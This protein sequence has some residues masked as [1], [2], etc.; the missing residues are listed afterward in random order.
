MIPLIVANHFPMRYSGG[1]SHEYAGYIS[2][3]NYT[4]LALERDSLEPHERVNMLHEVMVALIRQKSLQAID[5]AAYVGSAESYHAVLEAVRPY[6]SERYSE[7]DLAEVVLAQ[8]AETKLYLADLGERDVDEDSQNEVILREI[9]DRI[10]ADKPADYELTEEDVFSFVATEREYSH[11]MLTQ[12]GDVEQI[13]ADYLQRFIEFADEMNYSPDITSRVIHLVETVDIQLMTPLEI[14]TG[15]NYT[16]THVPDCSALYNGRAH[17]ILVNVATI[18][19]AVNTQRQLDASFRSVVYHELFHAS[20]VSWVSAEP[21]GAGRFVYFP[22]FIEEALAEKLSF[23]LL[24]DSDREIMRRLSR[25][26]NK[27]ANYPRYRHTFMP[28][29]HTMQGTYGGY[30]Y[31]LDMMMAKLDWRAAGIDQQEAER[32]LLA[33]LL[34]GPSQ[35]TDVRRQSPHLAVFHA[36]LSKASFP[37]FMRHLYDLYEY[38]GGEQRVMNCFDAP[39]F[40]PHDKQ[41]FERSATTKLYDWDDYTD[42]RDKPSDQP[43]LETLIRLGKLHFK[44]QFGWRDFVLHSEEGEPETYNREFLVEQSPERYFALKSLARQRMD[45]RASSRQEPL[46]A[47]LF[48]RNN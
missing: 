13:R 15:T 46:R 22:D 43:D 37:G 30:R 16:R 44:H 33:A 42:E 12:L 4:T 5:E 26:G 2:L 17:N 28:R 45:T 23:R 10:V 14:M 41:F 39:G 29:N 24:D 31:A 27:R 36:S 47:Q 38:E 19:E 48:S 35:L 34:D 7:T 32:Q 25:P 6:V 9:H 20:T 11:E 18:L 1:M 21:Q 8:Y 3:E 40:D